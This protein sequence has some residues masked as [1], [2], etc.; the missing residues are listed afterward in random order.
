MSSIDPLAFGKGFQVGQGMIPQVDPLKIQQARIAAADQQAQVLERQ[1]NTQKLIQA[2]A[3][4]RTQYNEKQALA[5]LAATKQQLGQPLTY[6][7]IVSTAPQNGPA[8]GKEYFANLADASK[9]TQEKIKLQQ[10][11]AEKAQNDIDALANAKRLMGAL[12]PDQRFQ[13]VPRTVRDLMAAG[14]LTTDQGTYYLNT[15]QEWTD[16][17]IDRDVNT[18]LAAHTAQIKE[19]QDRL[20]DNLARS[21]AAEADATAQKNIAEGSLATSKKNRVD[22][23][24]SETPSDHDKEVSAFNA[25][26]ELTGKY[27]TGEVGYQK[28]QQAM[29]IEKAVKTAQATAPIKIE[30][31]AAT[32][33][34]KNK[35][36]RLDYL[37]ETTANGR[38]YI[39]SSKVK[40]S[41]LNR[42]QDE[43]GQAGIPVVDKDTAAGLRDA[44]SVKAE[45]KRMMDLLNGRLADNPVSRLFVAPE[46]KALAI[47]QI[48]PNL[49]VTGTFIGPA[50]QSLRA[51]AGAKNFRITQSEIN[52]A[53]DNFVP[54][55][56]DTVDVA[57][58]KIETIDSF[59]KD[60]EDVVLGKSKG[61]TSSGGGFDADKAR[62]KYN[63]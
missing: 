33:A 17:T 48:D 52:A 7:D 57:K 43:A 3:E 14:H 39:D 36:P 30:T 44:A 60:K 54:K 4:L 2:N 11:Q 53:I 58:K 24:L 56:T 32:D 13:R 40:S 42:L 61:G 22:Q 59:L 37:T 62:Q 16:E 28:W 10:A 15:P 8:W 19:A 35:V 18:D 23:G 1:A 25:D 5:Q 29:G 63:Y 6:E 50:I 51:M 26:P 41:T 38:D 27:G 9:A 46:N 34:A 20:K 31:A 47:G 55:A 21:Q 49:A 45:Q 12:P